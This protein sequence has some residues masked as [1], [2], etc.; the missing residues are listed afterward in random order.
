[1]ELRM[2]AGI[3]DN[4]SVTFTT[5]EDRSAKWQ[6]APERNTWRA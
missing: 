4:G 3:V 6:H 1:M 5:H 2:R